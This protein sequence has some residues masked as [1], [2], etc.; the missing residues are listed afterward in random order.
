MAVHEITWM[1]NDDEREEL[2]S[3]QTADSNIVLISPSNII[4][5]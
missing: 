2:S 4:Q 1:K 5:Y 3:L